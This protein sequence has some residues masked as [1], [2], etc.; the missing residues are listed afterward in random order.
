M[1]DLARERAGPYVRALSTALATCAPNHDFV[2]LAEA[3]AHLAAMDPALSGP[4]LLPALVESRTGMPS[5]PWME[6]VI[7]ERA[8][9][10]EADP[11]S[12]EEV[13][14]ASRLD[15]V[16]GDRLAGRR[17]LQ[18]HLLWNPVLPSVRLDV[19]LR[20]LGRTADFAV[21]Y[22]RIEPL[23]S[24]LRIRVEVSAPRRDGGALALD[25]EGRVRVDPGLSHLLT[26]HA[27]VPLLALQKTVEG[28][29]RGLVVR[30]ARSRVGPF[31]FPGVTLPE[32]IPEAL[33]QGLLLHLETEVVARDIHVSA[34]RDPLVAAPTEAAPDG[35]GLFRERRFAA[36]R[37]MVDA[38][39]GWC[40]ARGVRT[41]VVG[42]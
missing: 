32:G 15:P 39:H 18:Q 25:D 23:G 42:F 5:Y 29:C 30:L 2:P 33:G 20:R 36:S 19:Q 6:R 22:D 16:L 14:R 40:M 24:W 26:R 3:L 8:L 27:A 34:H 41:T 17:R 28:V 31:W 1:I 10:R 12:E 4:Q 37:P 9:A 21:I 7:A 35:Q 13:A 11:P 38:V